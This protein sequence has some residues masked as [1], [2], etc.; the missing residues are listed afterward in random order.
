MRERG[1]SLI[2]TQLPESAQ[3]EGHRERERTK[4]KTKIAIILLRGKPLIRSL[5]VRLEN[6]RVIGRVYTRS[7]PSPTRLE[8]MEK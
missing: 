8:E 1:M 5:I 4:R 6:I 7:S 3:D 2:N